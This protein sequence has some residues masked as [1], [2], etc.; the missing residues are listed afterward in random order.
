MELII[1][2]GMSGAGKSC[3]IDVFEEMG[4]YCVDNMPPALMP[5]FAEICA[6]SNRLSKVAIVT[7]VRGGDFFTLFS[8]N[9]TLLEQ[10]G[11]QVKVLFLDA[12]DEK[13]VSRYKETRQK[14]PLSADGTPVLVAI[15]R[16]RD[17][18]RTAQLRADCTID[19]TSLTTA[20]LRAQIIRIFADHRDADNGF[21]VTVTTFGFKYGIPI[22]CDLV[23][24]VRF[25]PN[26]YYVEELRCLTG[27]QQ[28][29]YD[30]VMHNKIT[31]EFEQRWF[32]LLE[33]L[34]P[35]YIAEGKHSLV[36]GVGCTGGKHRSVTLG[37]RLHEWLN[38]KGYFSVISHRDI[39][40]DA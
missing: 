32:S 23:F 13:L 10:S 21:I 24:D 36:I 11:N 5:K 19:T 31:G 26:P 35:H 7:D 25:L 3:A 8:E 14:H 33:F 2:T 1:I 20:Q 28:E 39:H 12:S 29:V 30:F 38:Q 4:Y 15:A 27:L 22:D 37:R 18:T 6:A 16:E 9:V 40:R 34:L 17:L